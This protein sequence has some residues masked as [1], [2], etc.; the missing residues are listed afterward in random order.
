MQPPLD[1]FTNAGLRVRPESSR[2]RAALPHIV[3]DVDAN[4]CT[5]SPSAEGALRKRRACYQLYVPMQDPLLPQYFL[6][7]VSDR[8]LHAEA[9]LP[10]S[11]RNSLCPVFLSF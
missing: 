4:R 5:T 11:F 3:E 2:L 10:I 7:V 8:W 6:R 1:G 9:M